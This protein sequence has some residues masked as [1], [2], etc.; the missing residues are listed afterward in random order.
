MRDTGACAALHIAARYQF[1]AC[2]A[3]RTPF[4]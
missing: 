1:H 2:R 3:G 4:R